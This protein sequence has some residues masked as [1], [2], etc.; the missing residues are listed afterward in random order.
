MVSGLFI[1]QLFCF[2]GLIY[3]VSAAHSGRF[4]CAYDSSVPRDGRPTLTTQASQVEVSVFECES[5]GGVEWL[6]EDTLR[7]SHIELR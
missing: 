6:R 4:A 1:S 5:S 7:V 2:A 3:S